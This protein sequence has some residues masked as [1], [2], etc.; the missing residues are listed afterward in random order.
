MYT[1][2][3]LFAPVDYWLA[4][5]TFDSGSCTG[6]LLLLLRCSCHFYCTQCFVQRIL[7][8]F[9]V[10]KQTS[11][12]N[13]K[14][15]HGLHFLVTEASTKW[16]SHRSQTPQQTRSGP[17]GLQAQKTIQPKFYSPPPPPPGGKAQ[18][19]LHPKFSP[20]PPPQDISLEAHDVGV[21]TSRPSALTGEL[22][23]QAKVQFLLHKGCATE[24]HRCIHSARMAKRTR[25]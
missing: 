6:T 11:G 7:W 17:S 1:L 10:V 2:R 18:K 23:G 24:D 20:P 22:L 13:S 12:C 14:L 8:F 5:S 19:T 9:S 21:T 25:P 15:E 4:L 16:L 3:N